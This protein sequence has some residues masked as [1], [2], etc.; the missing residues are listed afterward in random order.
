MIFAVGENNIWLNLY[1]QIPHTLKSHFSD[2]LRH[3]DR[4]LYHVNLT[5]KDRFSFNASYVPA[6]RFVE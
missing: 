6:K 5:S 3:F 4:P 2:S 1:A